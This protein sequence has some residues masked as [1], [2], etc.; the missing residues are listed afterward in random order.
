MVL[1]GPTS[2]AS[3]YGSG[4]PDCHEGVPACSG[5]FWRVNGV[6]GEVNGF[7]GERGGRSCGGG[8]AVLVQREATRDYRAHESSNRVIKKYKKVQGRSRGQKKVGRV[9]FNN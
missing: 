6:Y 2:C 3:S 9:L 5:M 1:G 7:M 4:A 8:G